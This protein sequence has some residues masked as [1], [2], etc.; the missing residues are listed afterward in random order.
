M[1]AS[2]KCNDSSLAQH[3]TDKDFHLTDFHSSGSQ[4]DKL[5]DKWIRQYQRVRK[6]MEKNR[7]VICE[8]DLKGWVVRVVDAEV[9]F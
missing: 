3:G 8:S 1:S 4:K 9:T 6:V 2:A 5:A 7:R